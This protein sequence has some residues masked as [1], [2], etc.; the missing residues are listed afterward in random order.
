MDTVTMRHP[1]LPDQNITVPVTAVPHHQASG[2]EVL[3]EDT[4]TTAAPDA[5]AAP[6]AEPLPAEDTTDTK[7]PARRRRETKEGE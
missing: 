7:P 2:W 4:P 5:K 6:A 3:E 1:N